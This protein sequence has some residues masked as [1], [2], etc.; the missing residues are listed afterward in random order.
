MGLRQKTADSS[1]YLVGGVGGTAGR[2][3]GGREGDSLLATT[4][5]AERRLPAGAATAHLL[6]RGGAVP[7]R[8]VKHGAGR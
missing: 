3:R 4:S 1:A 7:G 2:M 8:G 6:G 5:G